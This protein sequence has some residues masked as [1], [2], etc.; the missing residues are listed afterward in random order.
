MEKSEKIPI[1]IENHTIKFPNRSLID[2][3]IEYINFETSNKYTLVVSGSNSNS[4]PGT[5]G[6]SHSPVHR[7]SISSNHERAGSSKRDRNS[8]LA[9]NAIT[10]LD[11]SLNGADSSID[12]V[13]TKVLTDDEAM[14]VELRNA[15]ISRNSLRSKHLEKLEENKANLNDIKSKAAKALMSNGSQDHDFPD[16]SKL[17]NFFIRIFPDKKIVIIIFKKFL[18][19]KSS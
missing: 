12:Q 16:E 11:A 13:L 19:L 15:A 1:S 8:D 18:R 7:K 5:R 17:F 3:I 10:D 2:K 9:K 14:I 6:K 4:R